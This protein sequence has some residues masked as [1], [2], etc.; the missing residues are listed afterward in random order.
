MLQV[1][2][3]HQGQMVVILHSRWPV[4]VITPIIKKSALGYYL[5]QFNDGQII[6]I[7]QDELITQQQCIA[8]NKI[9]IKPIW[10]KKKALA[11]IKSK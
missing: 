7:H 1:F 2:E 4:M 3:Y 5:V 9:L 8:L 11:L 10:L 6:R